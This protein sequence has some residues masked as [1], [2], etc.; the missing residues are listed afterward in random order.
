[1]LHV[2]NFSEGVRKTQILVELH[3]EYTAQNETYTISMQFSGFDRTQSG[4]DVILYLNHH[5]PKPGRFLM[6][7]VNVCF[8]LGVCLSQPL[9]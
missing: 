8:V 1:M 5:Y 7:A 2:R 3:S 6:Y 4:H 9:N